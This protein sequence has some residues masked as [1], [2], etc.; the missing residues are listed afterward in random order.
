MQL[1]YDNICKD[2]DPCTYLEK[3]VSLSTQIFTSPIES[4]HHVPNHAT[5]P[6]TSDHLIEKKEVADHSQQ[7]QVEEFSGELCL[8]IL[9]GEKQFPGAIRDRVLP[10]GIVD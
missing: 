1:Q 5:S 4:Y 6:S 2:D 3:F 7:P 8:L 9:R 10:V